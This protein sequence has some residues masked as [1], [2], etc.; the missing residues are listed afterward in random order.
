MCMAQD[1]FISHA[2]KDKSVTDASLGTDR[3]PVRIA[4]DRRRRAC[5]MQC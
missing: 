5:R 4:I 3:T 1:V 2:H